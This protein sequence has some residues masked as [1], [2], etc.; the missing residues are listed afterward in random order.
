MCPSDSVGLRLFMTDNVRNLPSV[1]DKAN[2]V[3][4]VSLVTPDTTPEKKGLG[5]VLDSPISSADAQAAALDLVPHR[6]LTARDLQ[7]GAVN[8]VEISAGMHD[9]PPAATTSLPALDRSIVRRA[10]MTAR[11]S[12]RIVEDDLDDEADQAPPPP[13]EADPA[14]DAP[15]EADPDGGLG[16]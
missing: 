15:R 11:A 9:T 6:L 13:L 4:T 8:G 14:Q 7:L 5:I 12:R 16:H 10:R 3:D 2:Q 1:S